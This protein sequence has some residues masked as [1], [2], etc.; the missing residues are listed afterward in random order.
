MKQ[1]LESYVLNIF[2][3]F[4]SLTQSLSLMPFSSFCKLIVEQI[5]CLA[6]QQEAFPFD[7][8]PQK[9]RKSAEILPPV[10]HSRPKASQAGLKC[11]GPAYLITGMFGNM[12]DL[13]MFQM[14]IES[15]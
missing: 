5:G 13:I 1:T 12:L 2:A 15:F 4:T 8:L 3:R 11:K 14:N 10:L 7:L 6:Q 9:G